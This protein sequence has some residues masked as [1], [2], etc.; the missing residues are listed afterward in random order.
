MKSSRFSLRALSSVGLSIFFLLEISAFAVPQ[1]PAVS[2]ADVYQKRCA[3]CHDKAGSNAPTR[4]ALQK[5]PAKHI[6]R[7]L[8]SIT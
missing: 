1:A 8:D 2:G 4:D 7:S 5:L 6:L 3:S